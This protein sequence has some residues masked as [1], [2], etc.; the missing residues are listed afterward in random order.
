MRPRL[1]YSRHAGHVTRPGSRPTPSAGGGQA[2]QDTPRQAAQGTG[3]YRA[4]AGTASEAATPSNPPAHGLTGDPDPG[5][6]N[7]P[8]EHATQY[9]LHFPTLAARREWSAE[10]ARQHRQRGGKG[11]E[12]GADDA[13]T[14][15]SEPGQHDATAPPTAQPSPAFPRPGPSEGDKSTGQSD[16]ASERTP[17]PGT[18]AAQD[19]DVMPPQPPGP[20]QPT[21]TAPPHP[22][23]TA[24]G[25]RPLSQHARTRPG[26]HPPLVVPGR[27]PQYALC[28]RPPA[29]GCHQRLRQEA[30]SL[31][32]PRGA[33]PGRHR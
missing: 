13:V 5:H 2:Q 15:H 8:S 25:L 26:R 6:R 32:H 21:D 9:T 16:N 29:A 14:E 20:P 4:V 27:P 11:E 17:P 30:P 1:T 7:Q 3:S 23:R 19:R 24:G 18:L 31:P 22:K 12:Q 28:C 33:F 10:T